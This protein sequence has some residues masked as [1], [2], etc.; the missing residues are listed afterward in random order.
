MTDT[1]EHVRRIYTEFIM[2][3]SDSERFKMGFEMADV[4][5]RMVEEQFQQQYPNWSIGERKSAVFE[6][7]YR[8]DFSADEMLH[9]KTSIVAYYQQK[10]A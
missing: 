2:Q 3:K 8:N 10:L 1:P 7:I 6:R 9:I 5:Q 4:G